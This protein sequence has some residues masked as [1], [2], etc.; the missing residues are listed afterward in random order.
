MSYSRILKWISGIF[1][2][3]LAIPIVGGAIVIGTGYSALGFMLILHAVTLI[4]SLR[5]Q[6][7]IYGSVWGILTSLL[8]WIPIIGW[9]LHL[10]AAILLMISGSKKNKTLSLSAKPTLTTPNT[11][12]STDLF[13]CREYFLL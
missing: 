11:P 8:A 1:E 9:V 5:N 2:L 6:E 7:A 12:D 3:V 13:C 10:I 4:L